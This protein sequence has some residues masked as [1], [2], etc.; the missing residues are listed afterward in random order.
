MS[1]ITVGSKDIAVGRARSENMFIHT[2]QEITSIDRQVHGDWYIYLEIWNSCN[3]VSV[4]F[5]QN[6]NDGI[7]VIPSRTIVSIIPHITSL[8]SGTEMRRIG[9]GRNSDDD[10]PPRKMGYSNSLTA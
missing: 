4:D 10:I 5:G 3:K 7:S 8:K 9:F 2:N 6:K 1:G